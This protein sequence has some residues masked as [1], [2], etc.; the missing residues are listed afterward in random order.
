VE[1]FPT[2]QL[3]D[4]SVADRHAAVHAGGEIHVVR[5]DEGREPARFDQLGERAEHMVGRLRIEIAG[6][7]VGQQHPRAVG[8]CA[9]DCDALLLATGQFRRAMGLPRSARP[10]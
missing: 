10:R 7:L 8:D 9:G 3:T 6:R 5:G 2:S 4:P 1:A